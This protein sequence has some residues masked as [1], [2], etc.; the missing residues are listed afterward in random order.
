MAQPIYKVWFMKPTQTGFRLT[1]E[2]QD[3]LFVQ[4]A[5]SLKRAG[6]ETIITCNS[7]W[8]SEEWQYWGVE[9]YPNIES[10]QQHTQDLL[11]MNWFEYVDSITYLGTELVET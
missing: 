11:N 8:A 3:K 1:K 5:E 10:V 9:K 7:A 4:S 6:A 2:E